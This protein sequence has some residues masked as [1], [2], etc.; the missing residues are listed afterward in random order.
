MIGRT[1]PMILVKE[2]K[3]MRY[4]VQIL[5][6]TYTTNENIIFFYI[7]CLGTYGMHRGTRH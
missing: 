1:V 7:N 4:I 6:T 3:E 2:P 5:N